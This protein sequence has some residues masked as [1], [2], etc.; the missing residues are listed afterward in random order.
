MIVV[1]FNAVFGTLIAWVLV[2]DEFRGKAVVN[3]LI[4][5]PFALPTI[6]AGVVLLALYGKDSP[7]GINVAFTRAAGRARVAVRHAP[8]RRPLGAAGAARARPRDGGGRRLAGRDGRSPFCRDRACRRLAPAIIS[9]V[10]LSF[11]RAVG[12]FGSLVLIT[13]NLP[14]KTE[15]GSVYIFGQIQNENLAAAAAVSVVLL[16]AALVVLGALDLLSPRSTPCPLAAPGA[17]QVPRPPPARGRPERPAARARDRSARA[18]KLG[19]RTLALGYLA[20]LLLAPV[21]MIFYRTFEHGLA[22]VWSSITAPGAMHA[23]WLSLEIVAIAVP[24]N[25]LFG[26]GMA[27]LLERG[28]FWARRS[29]AC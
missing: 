7:I 8:V 26:V 12:E 3:A 25:T 28:R 5:L 11:A 14:F 15:A 17:S 1:A 16:L 20:L 10:A 4:D 18:R 2:R 23:F 21:G 24:L 9:G 6:V 29:S 27:L 22:P 19:V 13:G